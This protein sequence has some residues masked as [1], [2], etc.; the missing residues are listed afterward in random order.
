VDIETTSIEITAHFRNFDDYWKPFLGGQE[1]APSFVL[2]LDEDPKDK[3]RHTLKARLPTQP[4][5]SISIIYG[6]KDSQ[7]INL[8]HP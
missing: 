1:P 8:L 4:D 2:S 3:L 5:G 7:K 6:K